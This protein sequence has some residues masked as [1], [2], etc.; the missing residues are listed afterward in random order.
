[1]LGQ[2]LSNTI[3]SYLVNEKKFYLGKYSIILLP[4]TGL[5][6]SLRENSSAAYQLRVRLSHFSACEHSEMAHIVR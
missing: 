1:M 6:R 2:G 5:V 4:V 3:D